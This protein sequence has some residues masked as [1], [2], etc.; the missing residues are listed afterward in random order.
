M[1]KYKFV[2]AVISAGDVHADDVVGVYI[3]LFETDDDFFQVG[4]GGFLLV[5]SV[6]FTV[7][8]TLEIVVFCSE[9]LNI[10][11]INVQFIFPLDHEKA[12]SRVLHFDLDDVEA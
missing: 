8:L 11:I 6:V 2:L 5:L 12:F 3:N 1:P 7:A 9:D 4:G 10:A